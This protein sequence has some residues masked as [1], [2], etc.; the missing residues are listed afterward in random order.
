MTTIDNEAELRCFGSR[1]HERRVTTELS[2]IMHE[3]TYHDGA[4]TVF[5]VRPTDDGLSWQEG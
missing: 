2:A 5:L 1:C 4:Q 3:H